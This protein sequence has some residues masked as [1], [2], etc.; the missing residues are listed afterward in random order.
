MHA[1]AEVL[2]RVVGK[3]ISLESLAPRGPPRG[4]EL[5]TGA[6]SPYRP[7]NHISRRLFN[8]HRQIGFTK[9]R[10][11]VLYAGVYGVDLSP[12]ARYGSGMEP[13]CGIGART[14]ELER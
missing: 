13:L 9:D 7:R 12:R 10:R 5:N 11:K 14:L 1:T 4:S 3:A 8:A 2:R 6:T